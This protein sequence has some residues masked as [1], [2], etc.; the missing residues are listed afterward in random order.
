MHVKGKD[1][2]FEAPRDVLRSIPGIEFKEMARNRALQR[3][4]GAGGGVKA[5]I[6]DLALDMAKARVKDV[7]ETGS[8]IVASTC[9]FCRR[10]IMDA[11]SAAGAPVKVVDVVELMAKSMGLDTTIPEN[12]YSKFQEQDVIVCDPVC[13]P[14]K[15]AKGTELLA[16]EK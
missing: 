9:P 10:N 6:P 7:E 13:R 3:C 14:A 11:R 16:E 15:T 12:P 8:Q 5:G 4:C 2:A 1:W